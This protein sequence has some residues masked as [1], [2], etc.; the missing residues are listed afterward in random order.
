MRYSTQAA[1][2]RP[3]ITVSMMASVLYPQIVP[4]VA[5]STELRWI[6]SA[7]VPNE[8]PDEGECN[9]YADLS[10]QDIG[11]SQLFIQLDAPVHRSAEYGSLTVPPGWMTPRL[12]CPF[13]YNCNLLYYL[14]GW[15]VRVSFRAKYR[16]EWQAI[17][18]AVTSYLDKM[19]I[20][21]DVIRFGSS[22]SIRP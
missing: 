13:P 17:Q 15:P 14:D 6:L 11:E 22:H 9:E 12:S 21:R 16:N 3:D 8:K 19:T 2:D 5:V 20:S 7:S 1:W 18:E 10:F 4:A